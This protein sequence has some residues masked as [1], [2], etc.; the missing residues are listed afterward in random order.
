MSLVL[1]RVD[2]R[3]VH[4]QVVV[5]WGRALRVHRILLVD[6]AVRASDWEQDLYRL[7]VPPEVTLE[8]VSVAEAGAR[9]T[10]LAAADERVIVIVGDVGTLERVLAGHPPITEV[11][12]GGLHTAPG[13]RQRLPY[14]FLTD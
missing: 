14:V 5:G 9:L 4:G 11:N 8:F 12:I 10:S 1:V 3:Y 7:G 2:D 13:R 6:D